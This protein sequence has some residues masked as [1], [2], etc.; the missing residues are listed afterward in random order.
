MTKH[1]NKRKRKG[2]DDDEDVAI[3]A[4]YDERI[5]MNRFDHISKLILAVD[6]DTIINSMIKKTAGKSANRVEYL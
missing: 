3:T 1:A 6:T 4:T 2:D 5:D